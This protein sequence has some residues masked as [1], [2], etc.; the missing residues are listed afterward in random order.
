MK[1]HKLRGHEASH[2]D[3]S[4]QSHTSREG[5]HD[6]HAG[7]SV[8]MFRNKFW[9]SL[10][11][12]IPTVVWGHMLM[13]LTAYQPPTFPGSQWIAPVFGTA[14]FLYGGRV[15]CKGRGRN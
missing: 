10:A 4:H 1:S 6:K 5:V 15:S 12:T 13:R 7:H 3:S 8:E 14:V 2:S 11:L 9:I